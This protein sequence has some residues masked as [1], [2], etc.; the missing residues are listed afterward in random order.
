MVDQA[1]TKSPASE[2]EWAQWSRDR[3]TAMQ[4][5]REERSEIDAQM[6]ALEAGGDYG[7]AATERYLRL[8][9]ERSMLDINERT[10]FPPH[11]SDSGQFEYG[12]ARSYFRQRIATPNDPQGL[13]FD[14]MSAEDQQRYIRR[15]APAYEQMRAQ[16]VA[17]RDA[18]RRVAG[19]PGEALGELL[20]TAMSRSLGGGGG[21]IGCRSCASAA[22]RAG[23]MSRTAARGAQAAAKYSADGLPPPRRLGDLQ[24]H[25]IDSIQR[26]AD[27]TGEDIY[28]TGSAARGTR[29]NLDT[30]LSLKGFG[31]KLP[32]GQTR[33]DI[34]YA[35]RSGADEIV[36]SHH[37][38][39]ADPAFGVRG[40]A[41]INLDNGPAIR[42]RPGQAPEY[43]PQGGGKLWLDSSSAR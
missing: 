28:V 24:P 4:P 18:Q 36:D 29:R 37:L 12:D 16:E 40:V 14:R 21:F 8:E 26:A 7:P 5:L 22:Q 2:A 6:R 25:E 31:T 23:T 33:S 11:I 13:A 10:T 41:Y 9:N 17:R 27:A 30:D 20:A 19:A 32:K 42:F 43:L 34:D 1:Q 38:P 35:V 15:N 3:A 39:D